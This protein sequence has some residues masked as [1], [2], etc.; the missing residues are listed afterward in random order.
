MKPMDFDELFNRR[1]ILSELE[2]CLNDD[3]TIEAPGITEVQTET[4]VVAEVFQKIR[5]TSGWSG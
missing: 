2:A 3:Y 4:S 1:V 5:H